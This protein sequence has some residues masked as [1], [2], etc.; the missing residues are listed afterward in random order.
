MSQTPRPMLAMT[1]GEISA[2]DG[3]PFRANDGK[4]LFETNRFKTD[5][6]GQL[7]ERS[8]VAMPSA[9]SALRFVRSLMGK[10]GYV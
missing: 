9:H 10:D 1:F 5:W 4:I 3:D 8:Y 7:R 2:P 6:L